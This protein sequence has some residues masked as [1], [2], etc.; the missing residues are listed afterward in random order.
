MRAERWRLVAVTWRALV[1]QARAERSSTIRLGTHEFDQY[2][3]LPR[4]Q[5]DPACTRETHNEP[6][7]R[8]LSEL[9]AC[10]LITRTVVTD[11]DGEDAASD[12]RLHPSPTLYPAETDNATARIREW[13]ATRPTTWRRPLR[14]GTG[15]R[16]LTDRLPRCRGVDPPTIVAYESVSPV[17]G[18]LPD[19]RPSHQPNVAGEKKGN[20]C[21]RAID[22]QIAP[23]GQMAATNSRR[24]PEKLSPAPQRRL[25]ARW[26]QRRSA[27][28]NP[29]PS[30]QPR[31]RGEGVGGPSGSGALAP[32]TAL[33]SASEA[34]REVSGPVRM[35]QGLSGAEAASGLLD[36][37]TLEGIA[38]ALRPAKLLDPRI[39]PDGL[40]RLTAKQRRRLAGDIADWN[41]LHPWILR[42]APETSTDP[43]EALVQTARAAGRHGH[44][45]PQWLTTREQDG[46]YTPVP[47]AVICRALGRLAD[48]ARQHRR[49][50]RE[51]QPNDTRRAAAIATRPT[52][53]TGTDDQP[54]TWGGHMRERLLCDRIPDRDELQAAAPAI[55]RLL[56]ALGTTVPV[57]LQLH[58]PHTGD[59]AHL[60][61][62]PRP[63]YADPHRPIGFRTARIWRK[64][65]R[66]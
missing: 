36:R 24:T 8:A 2:R 44:W 18:G 34:R 55:R 53:L 14:A 23:S 6:V 63:A 30:E 48:D 46:T 32:L 27:P 52:W 50:D 60:T 61:L 21:E 47:L 56:A 19:G 7:R 35:P 64:S 62:I 16:R 25:T 28:T 65:A 22:D 15:G 33:L 54:I 37:Q 1:S 66:G 13:F 20:A 49:E 57:L 9:E 4:M 5:A 17:P 3:L 43:R 11:G 31:H 12:I 39:K 45:H 58:D 42:I 38:G 40:G 26:V 29:Q 59:N 10:G 51:S 41:G